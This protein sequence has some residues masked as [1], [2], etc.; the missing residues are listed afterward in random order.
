MIPVEHASTNFRSAIEGAAYRGDDGRLGRSQTST[1]RRRGNMRSQLARATY[2]RV[3]TGL[4]VS[5]PDL[6]RN[7]NEGCTT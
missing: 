5:I 3:H 4:Q 6:S 7:A 2:Q 1:S